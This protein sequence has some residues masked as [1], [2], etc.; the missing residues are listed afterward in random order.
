MLRRGPREIVKCE[1]TCH[2]T[3]PITCAL[4]YKARAAALH[5][6]LNLIYEEAL[7][8]MGLPALDNVATMMGDASGWWPSQFRRLSAHRDR[9]AD[10][11][12]IAGNAF[13]G[14]VCAAVLLV[15]LGSKAVG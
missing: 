6:C 3:S 14:G 12:A 7:C 5:C 11:R 9:C 4:T 1:I 15:V 10:F 13:H 2:R 8:L